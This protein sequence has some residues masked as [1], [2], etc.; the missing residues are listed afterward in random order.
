MLPA[1]VWLS[2]NLVSLLQPF[3]EFNSIRHMGAYSHFI[4]NSQKCNNARK[5]ETFPNFLAQAS[6]NKIAG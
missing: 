4:N 3:A 1:V 6:T 5:R 2:S